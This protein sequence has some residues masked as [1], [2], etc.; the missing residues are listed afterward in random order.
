MGHTVT[1]LAAKPVEAQSIIEDL[2]TLCLCDRSDISL[3]AGHDVG[4]SAGML[5]GAAIA[6]GQLAG[7]AGVATAR[8]LG[9][10]LG[11]ASAV[12]SRQVSGF[13]VLSAAGQLGASLSRSA[14]GAAENL[15][16]ALMDFGIEDNL[17]RDYADALRQGSILII[18]NAK[19]DKMAQCARQVMATRGAV[20][21]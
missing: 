17:A 4:E 12:A 10:I 21:S 11:T 19:N 14:L 6:T 3:M 2:T 8:T 16:K 13:G 5:E 18:V 9:G 20:A 7:A 1:G 15:G